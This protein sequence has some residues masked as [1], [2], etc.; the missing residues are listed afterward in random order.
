MR[1]EKAITDLQLAIINSSA[2]AVVWDDLL[3]SRSRPS[4]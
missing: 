3:R 2:E 1:N 4:S